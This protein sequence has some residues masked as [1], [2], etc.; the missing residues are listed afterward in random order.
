MLNSNIIF[1]QINFDLY[2]YI[3]YF[4]PHCYA[5]GWWWFKKEVDSDLVSV[6][7]F[8]KLYLKNVIIVFKCF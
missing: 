5:T 3:K 4:H 7:N 8:D 1:F 2:G 6:N